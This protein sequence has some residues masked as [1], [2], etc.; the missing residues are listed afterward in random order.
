[1]AKAASRFAP[2]MGD[3]YRGTTQN[4]NPL[5]GSEDPGFDGGGYDPSLISALNNGTNAANN[6]NT[7][8]A[9]DIN[10]GY[11]SLGS[12]LDKR[13]TGYGDAASKLRTDFNAS[14]ATNWGKLSSD[15]LGG[16]QGS[17]AQRMTDIGNAY[18]AM[19]QSQQDRLGQMGNDLRERFCACSGQ[20]LDAVQLEPQRI[21]GWRARLA[22][23][24]L[25]DAKS[26][27]GTLLP[28]PHVIDKAD[29]RP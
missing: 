14:Q 29:P 10:A 26:K 5:D 18:G 15:V 16:L 1:M 8:R 12:S 28:S 9:N 11:L 13:I 3:I 27:H 25:S 19:G 17:N 22:L 2:T 7:A 23:P 6:A 20:Q 4:G 21:D 24:A